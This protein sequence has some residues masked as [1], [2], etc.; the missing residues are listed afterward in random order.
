MQRVTL[1]FVNEQMEDA[2]L[3]RRL[4]AM[5]RRSTQLFGLAVFVAIFSLGYTTF[6][7]TALGNTSATAM[8]D[9]CNRVHAQ[10]L[11][12]ILLC[13]LA[14]MGAMRCKR[15]M[16]ILKPGT[17]EVGTILFMALILY[18]AVLSTPSRLCKMQGCVM[19]EA[20]PK[21][22]N[23]SDSRILLMIDGVVTATHLGLPMR[24]CTMVPL[25]AAAVTLYAVLVFTVGSQESPVSV[26]F[27]IVF[28][29]CL[30]I[31]ASVG[32]WSAELDERM[33][34]RDIIEQKQRTCVAEYEL[35]QAGSRRS[36]KRRQDAASEPRPS[37]LAESV[38]ATALSGA[39]FDPLFQKDADAGQ[40][41]RVAE[42]GRA[43]HWL[44]EESE[45][46][47]LPESAVGSGGFGV[48][49]K[50]LFC[51]MLVAVKRPKRGLAGASLR[52]VP[53]LCNELR[54]LRHLRH[55]NIVIT[56]GSVILPKQQQ[57]MLV[58]ELIEGVAL[59][60][61]LL[62]EHH[63]PSNLERYQIMLGVSRA[64]LYMH[65]RSP[66]I[67]HGDLKA[68][69][70][71]VERFRGGIAH[72]KVLDFGLSR[73]VTRSARPLGGTLAWLAPELLNADAPV[74]CSADTY[75]F[76]R[77]VAFVATGVPPL[78]NFNAKTI[79]H[80]L[81]RRRP[82]LPTWPD[83]CVF[84]P[85]CMPLV[86]ACLRPREETRPRMRQIF[87]TLVGLHGELEGSEQ[88]ENSTFSHFSRNLEIIGENLAKE[89]KS[90]S[91]EQAA[92]L[93]SPEEAA[94]S[95]SS[96]GE[97]LAS[98]PEG[99]PL[100][101]N[102]AEVSSRASGSTVRRRM[103]RRPFPSL[104]ATKASGLEGAIFKALTRWNVDI[105]KKSCCLRHACFRIAGDLC[106]AAVAEA[107]IQGP[108]VKA[109]SNAQCANCG[110]LSIQNGVC[111][112]CGW[113][114]AS[115]ADSSDADGSATGSEDLR[116]SL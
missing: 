114:D 98:L 107:C 1:R 4:P 72:P 86:A 99:E 46:T 29:T 57:I 19:E 23:E 36:S 58:L 41:A 56:Y 8:S 102:H 50:A 71:M 110:V 42:M 52:R 39:V 38:P 108:L 95:V 100:P 7:L 105:P 76:G 44:I 59:Q 67:V 116:V 12:A 55:P 62:D 109:P 25:E 103:K 73:V 69:N 87:E 61:F 93:Q 21:Y 68:N 34:F 22:A 63:A 83:G 14:W 53:D 115:E 54:V 48:V 15:L 85:A 30:V 13:I 43:E 49:V 31:A 82:P 32:K 26:I 96:A 6:D 3:S 28:L 35:E 40:L 10:C 74:K 106:S 90:P 37:S 78:A 45:M 111:D 24:W 17:F 65:T 77:L 16:K 75:S 33:A 84:R 27:N 5:V 91:A 20:M 64:L 2:F 79:R 101:E 88:P 94:Q 9:T 70:I 11:A 97:R 60:R 92:L 80:A 81:K 47:I 18:V 89:E 104:P 51:G 112:L 113:G 66:R